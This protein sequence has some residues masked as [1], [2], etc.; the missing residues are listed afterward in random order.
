MEATR[1]DV[2]PEC[3]MGLKPYGP[4]ATCMSCNWT[5]HWPN[6]K[7]SVAVVPLVREQCVADDHLMVPD[8]PRSQICKLCGYSPAFIGV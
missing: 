6:P 1:S 7:P 8:G 5:G 4:H 2:C 3:G